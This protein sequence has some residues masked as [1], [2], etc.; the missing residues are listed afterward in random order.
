MAGLFL[1][2]FIRL[3]TVLW[4]ISALSFLLINL[5]PGD[6]TI[7][8]LGPA[9]GDP[10][11]HAQLVEQLGLN[12]PL[13]VRYLHWLGGV[14]H[15][16]FGQ[17][18]VLHQSV[19]QAIGQRL[20]VT[21]EMMI[22][23]EILAVAV[24]IPLGVLAARRPN[25]WFDRTTG[26]SVFALLALPAFILGVLLVYLFSVQWHVLPAS[27]TT[28][29]FHIGDGP[30]ATPVSIVL[31]VITLMAGQVAVFARVLRS[32]MLVT[33][34]EDFILAAQAKGVSE[35]RILFHHALRPSSFSLVTVVGITVAALVGGTIIVEELFAIPGMGGLIVSSILSRDYLTIQ[36]CVVLIAS[37]FVIMN[38]IVD[39]LYVVLDPR[40]GHANAAT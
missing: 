25:G 7:A 26:F 24:S 2:R 11:A 32:E 37:A 36:G 3:I 13:P 28:T 19:M 30:V 23:A 40:V 20:P 39:V 29:W 6:P 8:I 1:K 27:G 5:L 12:Q 10:A 31:P 33:L 4:A 9:A 35:W 14:L 18:Y 16:D 21:L 34:R 15:G 38:F 17:S 22:F